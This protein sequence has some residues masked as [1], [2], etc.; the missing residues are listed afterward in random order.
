MRPPYLLILAAGLGGFFPAVDATAA[1]AERPT[2]RGLTEIPDAELN[3]MRGRYTV[4]HNEVAW[5]GVSMISTWQDAAG[6]TLQSTMTLGMDFSGSGAPE[7][8]FTPTVSITA[9]DAPLPVTADGV[10]RS[11]DG[12]GLANASGL[13]Q[14]VQVAGDGNLANNLTQ[15]NVR[16]GDAPAAGTGAATAGSASTSAG[17]AVASA[18]FDGS[19]AQVM[20]QIQGQGAVRQWIGSGSLGQTIQLTSDNQQ[21]SNRMQ[22]DLVRQPLAANTMLAQNVAQAMTMTRGIGSGY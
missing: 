9:A 4:G 15:L 2:A 17:S 5:F 6:Q 22:V 12:S 19:A 20:L 14:S 18:S 21:V 16:D 10:Q 8:S 13:V 1:E 7:L 3:L 11:V